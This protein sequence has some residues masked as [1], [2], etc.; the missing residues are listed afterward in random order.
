MK[1][2]DVTEL[3]SNTFGA[4][5]VGDLCK[6]DAKSKEYALINHLLVGQFPYERANCG[7]RQVVSNSNKSS[8]NDRTTS[9]VISLPLGAVEFGQPRDIVVKNAEVKSVELKYF[10]MTSG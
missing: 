4:T 7:V 8:T 1:D 10:D 5:K 9:F 2:S 6:A 3:I